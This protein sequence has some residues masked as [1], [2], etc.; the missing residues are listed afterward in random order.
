MMTKVNKSQVKG[1][2]AR[3]QGIGL[4]PSAAVSSIDLFWFFL[5]TRLSLLQV[6]DGRCAAP[7]RNPNELATDSFVQ[8][9]RMALLYRLSSRSKKR[10]GNLRARCRRMLAVH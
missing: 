3:N 8:P 2:R 5:R 4:G 6:Q 7:G 1:T 10:R 9:Q